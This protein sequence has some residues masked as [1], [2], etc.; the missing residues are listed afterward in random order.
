[1]GAMKKRYDIATGI[2]FGLHIVY[3][4]R[5]KMLPCWYI[6]KEYSGCSWNINMVACHPTTPHNMSQGFS[7]R[8]G[9]PQGAAIL[10]IS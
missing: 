10:T 2:S 1:M 4:D 5:D 9:E 6:L 7:T 3:D 8:Q